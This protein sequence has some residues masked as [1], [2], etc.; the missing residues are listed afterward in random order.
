MKIAKVRDV[1]T[2]ERGTAR[3]AGLDLFIPND[4]R[5]SGIMPQER[6]LIPSGLKIKVPEGYMLKAE[7]KSGIATKT[8]LIVGATVV[9][10]DYQGE[11]HISLINTSNSMVALSPGMK[12]VQMVLTKVLYADVE[13]VE[14]KD[15]FTQTTERGSGGFGS[16]GV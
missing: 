6:M 13:I 14:E 1:K 11:I 8:G 5:P 15:L 4:F 9:D 3:S 16:T 2:P 10:E 12:I 7:N